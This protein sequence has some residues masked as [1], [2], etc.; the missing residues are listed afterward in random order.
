M[1]PEIGEYIE[2]RGC[3]A[4]VDPPQHVD[5]TSTTNLT[6][7][8]SSKPSWRRRYMTGW[9][10][11]VVSCAA[12]ASIVF[13]INVSVTLWAWRRHG[14][15]GGR[16]TLFDGSCTRSRPYNTAIHVVI[17]IL[18][19]LLLSASNCCMQCLSAPTR[20]EIDTAH[21]RKGWLDIGVPSIRNLSRIS[22]RKTLL[23]CILGLS[24]LPL[25][26]L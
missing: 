19:T 9:R 18:S 20:R 2:L 8:A 14:F 16:G 15:T 26:L 5:A 11:G 7:S 13:V 6:T 22:G 3:E 17:N 21:S 24:S 25:H 12:S 10:F 4:C 23:W 1:R